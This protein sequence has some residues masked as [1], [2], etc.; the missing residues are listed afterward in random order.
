MI[1]QYLVSK[2]ALYQIYKNYPKACLHQAPLFADVALRFLFCPCLLGFSCLLS[3]GALL[4][5]NARLLSS[6]ALA[7]NFTVVAWVLTFIGALCYIHATHS[8][9]RPADAPDQILKPLGLSAR[10]L[11]QHLFVTATFCPA[12]STLFCSVDT[13]NQLIPAPLVLLLVFS[14][15]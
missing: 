9:Q 7:V 2:L 10:L 13:F 1:L 11:S 15:S 14:H 3:I 8:L 6:F 4:W 12:A 5:I